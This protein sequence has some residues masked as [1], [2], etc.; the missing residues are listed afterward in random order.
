MMLAA[1]LRA[2]AE[3]FTPAGEVV[4]TIMADEEAGSDDGARFLVE[5]H[6]GQ[7]AGVRYA[8]GEGG[9]SAQTMAS[10]RSPAP[11]PWEAEIG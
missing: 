4:L 11:R 6:A 8:I 1:V 5:Q 9:G 7:F 2:K 3:A 10:S